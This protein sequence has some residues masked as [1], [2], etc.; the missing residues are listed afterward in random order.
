MSEIYEYDVDG[1]GVNDVVEVT[2][3][4]DG[5]TLVVADVDGDGSSD[6]AIYDEDGDGV[7]DGVVTPDGL[8]VGYADDTAS[9]YAD[10]TADTTSQSASEESSAPGSAPTYSEWA[11]DQDYQKAY[12]DSVYGDKNEW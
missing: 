8:P 11:Q 7:A 6:I 4:S 12:Q 2:Q 10:D 9:G 3:Y 1:D 5:S